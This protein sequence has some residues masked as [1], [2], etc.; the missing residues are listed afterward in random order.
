VLRIQPIMSVPSMAAAA[1][2][3]SIPFTASRRCSYRS[4]F[5]GVSRV[6]RRQQHGNAAAGAGTG[7]DTD[8]TDHCPTAPAAHAQP[9]LAA[10]KMPTYQGLKAS[11]VVIVKDLVQLDRAVSM[12]LAATVVGIDSESRPTRYKGE[13]SQGPHLIQIATYDKTFLFPIDTGCFTSPHQAEA[14]FIAMRAVLEHDHIVKVGFGLQSDKKL[15]RRKMDINMKNVIDLGLVL[16]CEQSRN[17]MGVKRA[18]AQCLGLHFIKDKWISRSN[19]SLPVHELSYSQIMYA[20]NDAH[21][22]LILYD[23]LQLGTSTTTAATTGSGTPA[24]TVPTAAAAS[25]AAAAT[26]TEE[27]ES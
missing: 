18:V 2:W 10:P 22:A 3:A 27:V 4:V 7:T 26:A 8:T 16:R 19:W 5:G 23:E 6:L 15:F 1:A 9:P 13:V 24:S 17:T 12:L 11:D 25:T 20:A 14:L 21:V